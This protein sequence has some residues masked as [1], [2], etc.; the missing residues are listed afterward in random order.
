MT[1]AGHARGH[2]SKPTSVKDGH[3]NQVYEDPDFLKEVAL[4]KEAEKRSI[5]SPERQKAAR[6]VLA[7]RYGLSI[8]DVNL[9]MLPIVVENRTK[10]TSMGFNPETRQFTIT[11]GLT[12]TLAEVMTEWR[13]FSQFRKT[14]FPIKQTK[15]KPAE[16]PELLYAMF[17]ARR[18]GE[19]FRTIFRLYSTGK[20]PGYNGSVAQFKSEDNLERYYHKYYPDDKPAT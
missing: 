8:G 6:Q 1:K 10:S 18:A 9:Y 12:T 19:T 14:L 15:R 2:I 4:I 20:L 17:K 7:E 11:F 3:L 16:N 13:R 5:L